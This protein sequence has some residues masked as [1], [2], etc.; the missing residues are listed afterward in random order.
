MKLNFTKKAYRLSFL[1][2]LA[3]T[4]FCGYLFFRVNVNSDMTKYLPD[5]SRMK[6]GL[7]ILGENFDTGTLS[8][9]DVRVMFGKQS[10]AERAATA[11]SIRTLHPEVS[12]VASKVSAD[13]LHTLYE[14]TV[15]KSIDQK[16]LGALICKEFDN[17]ETAESSQDGATP[18]ISVI[19]IAAL[20]VLAV[21]VMM[22]R[23]WVEP[24][25]LLISVG[26]AVLI[27]I[28]TN[29]F[30][31]SVS[32]TTNYIG[33]ILQLVLSLDYSII[34][35]NRFRQERGKGLARTD[36]L[37]AAI[38][39]ATPSI[40][41]SALTTVA[42]LLMLSFMKLKIGADIGLVLA[43]GVLCSLV[44]NFTAMP[45]LLIAFD[46]AI[47][48]TPK[49]YFSLPT[50]ALARFTMRFRI[51]L[52]I[53]FVILFTTVAI[54]QNRTPI[55]FST[56]WESRIAEY[57]PPKNT[58]VL[59]YSDEDADVL[60]AL[61]DSILS[62]NGVESVLSY[63]GILQRELTAHDMTEFLTQMAD[64]FGSM[65]GEMPMD[66]LSEDM[67]G[68][69]Y[70]LEKGN[71]SQIK[72]SFPDLMDFI[73]KEADSNPMIKD[74]MEAMTS[75][76]SVE[77]G[78]APS[79]DQEEVTPDKEPGPEN[80]EKNIDT[81]STLAVIPSAV[82]EEAAG[83]TTHI[84]TKPTES[85][86]SHQVSVPVTA[87]GF[88]LIEFVNR[89]KKVNSTGLMIVMEHMVDTAS[90]RKPMNAADMTVFM[91]STPFQTKMVYSMS[92]S[93]K[94]MTPLQFVHFLTDD[95]FKRKSLAAMVKEDQKRQLHLCQEVMEY[96]AA[97]A[98]LP[99]EKLSTL[100]QGF[101]IA[102]ISPDYV[103]SL[104][105][106][107]QA[108]GMTTQSE[109]V[110]RTE[111]AVENVGGKESLSAGIDSSYRLVQEDLPHKETG[112]SEEPA[113]AQ[114][115]AGHIPED[116]LAAVLDG[117]RK[118]DAAGMARNFALMGQDIDLQYVEMLYALYGQATAYDPQWTMTL[119]DLVA[120][121][122]VRIM[123][124]PLFNTLMDSVAREQFSTM[125][126]A[127]SEVGTR[128]RGNGYSIAAIIS[129]FADESPET[130]AF[131]D[132]LDS[133]CNDML[134]HE[135][136]TIGESVM[137]SEMKKGFN[138]EL[139]VVTLLTILA[140][141]LIVAISFR[142]LLV[143]AV[144]VL[145]VL[146][147]IYVNVV[148]CGLGGRTMLYLA[149]LIVQSI[150]M[151]A[152]IDYGILFTN[153]YKECRRTMDIRDALAGAYKASRHTI[154]TSGTILTVAPGAMAL[155]V[156]NVTISS[157]VGCIAIGA[158]AA[159]TLILVVLPGIIATCDR[160]IV[161]NYFDNLNTR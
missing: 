107:Q 129:D 127:M 142:S 105:S 10:D 84:E 44:C 104:M 7:T 25:P 70:F 68:T 101:D 152:T 56:N 22:S 112:I 11:D 103:R 156:D 131:I 94:E 26:M 37:N 126:T 9:P 155:M 31:E 98:V 51:P 33:S 4:I 46:S 17:A 128:M 48:K 160:L 64:Q 65:T 52:T 53:L 38:P 5:D 29:A 81:T 45:L 3:V 139:L 73:E 85:L 28:G 147:G 69:L 108:D 124:N 83:N 79:A 99:A 150:L 57:F 115:T 8:V 80:N 95:L 138:R 40:L 35:M 137:F 86:D 82:N 77:D 41:S 135:H 121:I 27:N 123:D 130:Y 153:C 117:S 120:S 16:K 148:F 92:K 20:L 157:I 36:A 24:L 134:D 91:N 110:T 141:F 109:T 96:A 144:L 61:G 74:M 125:E 113:P 106:A 60:P 136:Y 58:I 18:P 21:L 55:R 78:G 119:E 132:K 72:V 133:F 159:V 39:A 13:S 97:D 161:R 143:P 12:S 15:P 102:G 59:L 111:T 1:A 146:T 100:A 76:D 140:T 2:T 90:A 42:G 30:L 93:G 116:P 118:Y 32:I 122:K 43:K 149:Y 88:S 89:L 14:L 158:F 151:G 87:E 66:M 34:L 49:H 50:D 75:E 23:S 67:L 71:P 47:E 6:R 154:T 114:I 63:Q 62:I 54:L 19:V 145:T